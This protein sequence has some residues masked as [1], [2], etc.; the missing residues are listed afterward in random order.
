M[1][2]IRQEDLDAGQIT[3]AIDQKFATGTSL[4]G[5]KPTLSSQ[6][7]GEQDFVPFVDEADGVV[8]MM[9]PGPTAPE[10]TL[11]EADGGGLFELTHKQ[12]I[13][14]DQVVGNLSSS[15]NWSVAIVTKNGDI[16]IRSATSAQILILEP[17]IM[18]P[19]EH[20]KV[21][22]A[23]PAGKPWVRIYVRSDQIRH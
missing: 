4:S 18:M 20:L 10:G 12:P 16:V 1:A 8:K 5:V 2:Y 3:R 23:S 9:N 6:P 7:A 19:G 14:L 13:V 22:C 15:V 17:H 21:T 11:D